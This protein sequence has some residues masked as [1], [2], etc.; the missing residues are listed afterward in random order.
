MAARRRL[1]RPIRLRG[2]ALFAGG[3]AS[4][5]LFPGAIGAGWRWAVGQARFETLKPEQ[6][7][8]A[9]RRSALSGRGRAE[10]CEHLLAALLI[11]DIDDCDIRFHQGEAPILDGSARPWLA[12]IRHAGVLGR[13]GT[14]ALK[15]GVRYGGHE[16]LWTAGAHEGAG[17]QSTAGRLRGGDIGSARTFIH[18]N[19]GA[20]LRRSGLF[21]GAR[22]GCALVLAQRG[23]SAL[24][25]GRP[26]L[27]N[28]P[29]GHK[30]LD[31]LGDL[32][33]WR[34]RGRLQG[35]LWL[36]DPGHA[37]NGSAIAKAL[38]DRRLTFA[39]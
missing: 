17:R 24:Y 35:E 4:V 29:L 23:T 3:P 18:Q 39:P 36:D 11:A 9:G 16:L 33:P 22:P 5:S 25:G 13:R 2:R 32:A 30:L 21:L 20:A 7:V 38:R 8:A 34:A 12:A 37:V 28:E 19:E 6:S 15:V 1:R 14:A 31:V 26:R 27:P 10:L